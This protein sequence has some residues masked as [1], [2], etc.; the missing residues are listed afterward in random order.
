MAPEADLLGIT[1]TSGSVWRD[2]ATAHALRMLELAGRGDVPVVPGAVY[3][4]VNSEL[5]TRR[6]EALY[7]KL[8]YKGAW[9]NEKWPDGT[10]QSQPLYHAHDTVPP[11]PERA[12][13]NSRRHARSRRTS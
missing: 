2:E 9:M 7:G 6:W 5:A 3:P 4:L 1:T 13:R 12:I 11:L 8:V 10:L